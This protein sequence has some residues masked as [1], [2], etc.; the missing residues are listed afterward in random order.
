MPGAGTRRRHALWSL[1][2]AAVLVA[3]AA[4]PA[5]AA[6]RVSGGRVARSLSDLHTTSRWAYPS[7]EAVVR[8]S[9]SG[10]AR[11]LG[12]LRFLT[13]DDQAEIYLALSF[14]RLRSGQTWVRVELPARP[15]GQSGW[16]PRDALGAF[17]VVKGYLLVDQSTLQATL[18]R[19]GQAIFG[20]P[21]GVGKPT[22]VTP[23][24][25]F[26]VM[27]KLTTLDAPFYGPYAIGT[28]AYAPTLTEWPGGGVVGIHGT[29]EPQL[30]PGRPSHGC[31]RLRNADITRLWAVIAVG[32]PIEIT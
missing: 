11:A 15:N 26:Y 31:V 18:F 16:V 24:G 28:S 7:T 9:P 12:R 27:E 2:I 5:S 32:T 1:L 29:S 6:V 23:A 22:T 4:E 8:A 14:E 21:I 13:V 17:H 10:G 30:I 25:H 20:A 19:D 3:A